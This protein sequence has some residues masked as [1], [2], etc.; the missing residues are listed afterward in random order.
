MPALLIMPDY[1]DA[2][3]LVPFAGVRVAF[4]YRWR[5]RSAR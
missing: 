1:P 2:M 3:G 5:T 4:E